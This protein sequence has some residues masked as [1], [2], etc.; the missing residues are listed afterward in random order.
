MANTVWGIHTQNDNLFL[1][2][3][4]IAIGWKAFGNL[5]ELE[6]TRDA[7]KAHYEKSYPDAKKGSIA[8]SAGM[9]FRFIHE[10]NIGDYVVFP[11]KTNR[12]INIGIIEGAYEYVSSSD[13]YV[14]QR[15]VKWLKH[16]P[17]TVRN[18]IKCRNR[19][20]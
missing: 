15:K 12:Q 19:K 9:L 8:T 6:A 11:S 16:L 5:S 3:N 18:R 13:E 10:V 20:W 4:V 17:R 1:K 7:F 2:N 14:Q